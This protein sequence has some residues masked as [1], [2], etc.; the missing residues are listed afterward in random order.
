MR[1]YLLTF[2]IFCSVLGWGTPRIFFN[3]KIYYT[4]DHQPYIETA[5]Q[6]SSA[7]MKFI[8]NDSGYLQANL[9]ITQIFKKNDQIVKVDKYVLSSPEMKDSVVEDFF[10]MQ[11]FFITSR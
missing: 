1:F 10:D 11:R 5:I 4:I 9:E 6:F 2:L 7:T 3:Y 8:A